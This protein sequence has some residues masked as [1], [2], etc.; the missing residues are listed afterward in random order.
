ML[1]SYGLFS[2]SFALSS[3]YLSHL[4][5]FGYPIVFSVLGGAHQ[6]YRYRRGLGGQLTKEKDH[7]TSLIPFVA[8][9]QGKQSWKDLGEELKWLNA[10]VGVIVSL[11]TMLI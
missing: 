6:D 1:F 10:S 5:M 8:L 4:I 7:K 9:F 2:L 11:V 3:P